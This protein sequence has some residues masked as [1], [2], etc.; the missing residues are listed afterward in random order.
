MALRNGLR[1]EK[2]LDRGTLVSYTI[3]VW[4][5]LSFHAPVTRIRM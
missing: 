2:N 3:R 5:V 4:R 1:Q